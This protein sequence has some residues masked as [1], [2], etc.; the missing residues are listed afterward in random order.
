MPVYKDPAEGVVVE[1]QALRA[2]TIAL[3]QSVD[4]ALDLAADVAEVLIASDLRGIASHGTARLPQ[5]LKLVK[6]GVLDPSA[7]PVRETGK[8]ALARFDA[9]NGWG[10][11]AG[12]I[13]TDD[14]I[15]RAH[16]FGV[17]ISLVHNANHYGIA[18]WYAMRMAREGLIGVSLTNAAPMVAPTRARVPMLG[19]NPIA[20]AAPAG[21][22]GMLVLD[23]ATS[24]VPRGRI[25]VAARRGETII[26][27]GW[28]IGS[29]GGPALTPEAALNG[30]L[31]PLG[32]GEES[33]G[34]KG[35]G[36]ALIVEMLTG[37]L[38]GA[39]CGP[40]ILGLFSTSANSDLGQFFMA[41]D[42][43]LLGD[44]ETFE[45]RLENLLED[46]TSAPVIPNAPGP[47]LYPG[48]PEAERAAFQ[49]I[50]GIAMDSQAHASLLALADEHGIPFPTTRNLP[51]SHDTPS[52]SAAQT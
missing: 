20:V 35:Y 34:Y 30:A 15:T 52:I 18:G 40:N 13:A 32:G 4:T 21:R 37:V 29:D 8:P 24:T 7:R 16:E 38:C 1:E 36:L 10:Q 28:A 31:Q 14:A 26:P 5:Y 44:G 12:R 23:M 49:Q 22:F 11:P 50:H 45:T 33:G 42:P 2:W 41:I 3:L 39:T 47:V 43:Y 27:A 17:A 46:L 19:T 25:E 51:R 6:A 48:Q 9:N